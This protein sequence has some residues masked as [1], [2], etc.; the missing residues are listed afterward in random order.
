MVGLVIVA[1]S[2]K[3][4]EGVKELADQMTGGKVRVVAAGGLD[5][6]TLGTSVERIVAAIDAAYGPEGVLVF[7]D[8]GSAVM[9]AEMA[10]EMLPPERRALVRL[11]P[12]PLV[13]GAVAAAVQASLGGTLREVDAAARR[14][15]ELK[16]VEED[17]SEP[18]AGHEKAEVERGGPSEPDAV[19]ADSEGLGLELVLTVNNEHGLHARPAALF[20]QTAARFKSA[21]T[22]RNLTRGTPAA[23]AKSL[24]QVLGLGVER[25]HRIAVS[26][27]GPDQQEALKAIAD[28]IEGG[29][30]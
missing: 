3:L 24:I 6:E 2:F 22:V 27:R 30:G 25:G 20:T 16:K 23:N 15:A 19:D 10:L 12:A 17:V 26:V 11:C 5:E 29:L 18:P 4:A 9:S 13:E 21:V 8:L 28:L 7:M 14:A 1:H